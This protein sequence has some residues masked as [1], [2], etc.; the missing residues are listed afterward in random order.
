MET[1]ELTGEE[2]WESEG[3][4]ILSPP[5]RKREGKGIR[6]VL[7]GQEGVVFATSGSSGPP[8]WVLFRRKA[9][10]ASARAVNK[11]LAVS[12]ADRFML[13]LPTF[14]VGGFGVVARAYEAGCPLSIMEGGWD[15]ARFVKAVELDR[16]TVTSLVPTQVHD[17]IALGLTAPRSLRVVIAGGGRL[18]ERDGKLARELGWPVLQT[19]G[20][21]EAGSQIATAGLDSLAEPFRADDLPILPIWACRTS[22]DGRLEFK[23]TALCEC[24]IEIHCGEISLQKTRGE[25]GWFKSSDLVEIRGR[26]LTM[27]GRADRAVKILGEL[28]D[29]EAR[30]REIREFP[31]CENVCLLAVPDRRRGARLMLF[32]EEDL[33]GHPDLLTRVNDGKAG[34][35]R[36]DEIF[37]VRR[38]PRTAMGKVDAGA[39]RKQFE[40]NTSMRSD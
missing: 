27:I 12:E 35:L 6:D 7:D 11:H 23:G 20:M 3:C 29:V 17:L 39:L 18:N 31:G 38:L 34:I 24:Y 14:H 22:A 40:G 21:T 25:E 5:G 13:A 28:V 9:L 37:A 19:Y 8:K 10:L 30:E 33:A 2:F 16:S 32:V 26:H 1:P 4:C 15:A 36:I